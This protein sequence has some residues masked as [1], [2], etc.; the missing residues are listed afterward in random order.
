MASLT[1]VVSIDD[2]MSWRNIDNAQPI[3]TLKV[4]YTSMG[5][6]PA[7]LP[8]IV[9]KHPNTYIP[10]SIGFDFQDQF[11]DSSSELSNT[12]V[13]SAE[14]AKQASLLGLNCSDT[15]VIYDDFG[16]F[17]ASRVWFMFKT[18][19]HEKVYVLEGGLPLYLKR[20]LPI[21]TELLTQYNEGD[22]SEYE[23]KLDPS[24]TFVD[25]QYILDNLQTAEATLVDAR[26]NPR[27]L[28]NIPESKVHL[29]AGHIPQSVNI[30]YASLQDDNACFLPTSK[31]VAAFSPY[32]N[33][34]LVFSCGSGVTACILA[35]AAILAGIPE[36]KVY[37]GSWSQWGAN[38]N[39]PIEIGKV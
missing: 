12:M 5:E 19:G 25:Q 34:P 6:G 37:D 10:N 30:H 35:Q 3:K 2:F 20:N 36:V 26:S 13:S 4:L 18:M 32:M 11:A 22:K 9:K 7:V 27:F 33:K 17:C 28:G 38:A 8:D 39:L 16:N 21:S 15:L 29:R 23:C 1:S 31:L 14:F 24:F